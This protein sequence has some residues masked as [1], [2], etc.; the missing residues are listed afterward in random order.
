MIDDK[1]QLVGRDLFRSSYLCPGAV[2]SPVPELT[3]N[4]REEMGTKRDINPHLVGQTLKEI[5]KIKSFFMR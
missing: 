1:R 4:K 5:F 2:D 3:S